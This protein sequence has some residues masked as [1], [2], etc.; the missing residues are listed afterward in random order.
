VDRAVG[1]ALAALPPAQVA[2]ARA[3]LEVQALRERL[4][5]PLLS[6]FSA[7]ALGPPAD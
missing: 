6:L 3:R 2:D 1:A 5:L 7:T 4:G